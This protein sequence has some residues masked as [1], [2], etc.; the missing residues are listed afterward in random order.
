MNMNETILNLAL[1][2][3]PTFLLEDQFF[4][5]IIKE[6]SIN[7]NANKIGIN[8]SIYQVYQKIEPQLIH[9]FYPLKK[10]SELLN[11]LLIYSTY[12]LSTEIKIENDMILM[13]LVIAN[14]EKT[15]TLTWKKTKEESKVKLIF[16]KRCNGKITAYDSE[17]HY[18]DE[19]YHEKTNP[20]AFNE[21]LADFSNLF[22]LP[23]DLAAYYYTH[24]EQHQNELNKLKILS[25]I[26]L[27]MKTRPLSENYT[28]IEPMSL[29]EL[30]QVII[31]C[32]GNN[33]RIV[34]EKVN[35]IFKILEENILKES[36][37][38]ISNPL[39]KSI[40]NYI[41]GLTQ[42]IILASGI[43]LSKEQDYYNYYQ[44]TITNEKT[45]IT[46]R[47]L[48][49]TKAR[50]LYYLSKKNQNIEGLSD[51]FGISRSR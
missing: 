17:I 31:M 26:K 9:Y 10:E 41:M 34:I 21:I 15:N 5:S 38:I 24:F 43:I 35:E 37:I 39:F 20:N 49:E 42:D 36:Q 27:E 50:E 8:E 1:A 30:K 2:S 3:L 45:N 18:Y 12:L 25:E 11:L 16:Q 14:G 51:F 4:Q 28:F 29:R 6:I 47:E 46:K 48:T 44:I 33:N 19:N 7:F 13:N 23:K 32:G 22:C 40:L